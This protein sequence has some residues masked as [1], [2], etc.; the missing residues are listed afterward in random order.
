MYRSNTRVA[1]VRMLVCVIA[2]FLVLTTSGGV[3]RGAQTRS[4]EEKLQA[5]TDFVPK[6]TAPV[7]QLIEVAQRFKIPMAIEWVDRAV[8]EN[9]DS[10]L[11]RHSD[12]I[13]SR[14]KRSVRTLIE[15]IA[16]SSPEHAIEVNEGLVRIYSPT[17]AVHPFNFLNVRLKRY[18]VKQADLL[19]AE[20]Q[21]RWA[22][23]F[24][25]APERYV[26]GYNGG[27][28][29]GA[30]HVFQ[31]PK[32]SLFASEVTVREI[33]NRIALAQGNA[34]WVATIK[35]ADLDGYAPCWRQ[36]NECAVT[37]MW[38]FLPLAEIAE[39]AKENLVVDVMIAG[40]L[41]QRV[42][43]IPVMLNPGLAGDSG[44]VTG[45]GSSEGSYSYSAGIEEIGKDFVRVSVRLKVE[46]IGELEFKFDERFTEYKDRITEVAPESRIRIRTYFERTY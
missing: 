28:G 10:A 26:N 33:L 43:T 35:S 45:G 19:R 22:I 31:I 17:A 13:P 20:D 27:Y 3:V 25:L 7:D 4:L 37:S 18:V 16:R 1:L 8:T 41:D 39:L 30:N 2:V 46:R 5:I 38:K 23:R 24:T 29:H 6:A 21:L 36:N 15:E 44:G 9:P 34:L 42:T 11:P 32:F 14:W 12:K 40:L